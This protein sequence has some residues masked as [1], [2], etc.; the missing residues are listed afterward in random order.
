PGADLVHL[1]GCTVEIDGLVES[2]G[3]GHVLPHN[4]QTVLNHCNLDPAAHPVGNAGFFTGCIEIWAN[5]VVIDSTGTHTGELAAHGMKHPGRA[6]IDIFA[7]KDITIKGDTAA[8]YAVHAN[9]DGSTNTFAGLITVKSK[10]GKVTTSGLAI[11]ANALGG[12]SDG[13]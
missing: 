8:P 5:T 13:G 7:T 2:S 4:G 9:P 12:G 11:Q 3:A 10:S 6:W 1:Q